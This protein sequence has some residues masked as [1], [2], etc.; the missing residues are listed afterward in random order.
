MLEPL[1][2]DQ[3]L[4]IGHRARGQIVQHERRMSFRDQPIGNVTI[5]DNLTGRLDY[6]DGTA[7]CS[8]PAEFITEPND[9]GSLILRWE[10]TDPLPATRG[11]VIRFRCRVR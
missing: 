9:A 1:M 7:E 3:M 2:A 8:V 6:I 10:I 5:M 4:D 11:G